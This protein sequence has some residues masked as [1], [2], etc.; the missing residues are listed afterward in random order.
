MIIKIDFHLF[1]YT[2]RPIS[3][4]V[5]RQSSELKVAG[6]SPASVA[7]CFRSLTELL[8]VTFGTA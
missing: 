5:E 7:F 3:S 4:M 1:L 2:E 8:N 6:S